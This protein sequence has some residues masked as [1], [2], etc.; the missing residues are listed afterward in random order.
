MIED[1]W[2]L[3]YLALVVTLAGCSEESGGGP[4]GGGQG[5]AKLLVTKPLPER[6]VMSGTR[7]A[8]LDPAATGLSFRNN[9]RPEN[10]VGYVYMGAGVTVGDY[11]Q[12]GLLDLYFVSQDGANKLFRQVT[13]LKFEDVTKAAG[14]GLDGGSA[15]GTAATFADVD[16][17]A[18]LDLFVCNLESPNLLFQNQGDGTFVERAG[19]F[20]LGQTAASTG[21]AFA[22]Y[23]NDGD[24]DLYLLANRVF[25]PTLA[26]EIVGA[27]TLPSRIQKTRA[28]LLAPELTFEQGGRKFMAGQQDRLFRNDGYAKFVDVTSEVGIKD[29]GNGLSV[30]W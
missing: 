29:H 8:R 20:G 22:D 26:Q 27:T 13:P 17:D 16:G 25:R 9:L 5:P 4:G 18:D 10:V 11:D 3:G 1:M 14:Q 21:A 15:W 7:F 12:D 23:D 30:V 6:S 28:E 24:L 2:R 19:A